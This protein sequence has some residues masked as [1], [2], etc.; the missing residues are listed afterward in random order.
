MV[1]LGGDQGREG[2]GQTFEPSRGAPEGSAWAPAGGISQFML[3][4]FHKN[5]CCGGLAH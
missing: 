1:D 3:Q 2:N 5:R 4:R